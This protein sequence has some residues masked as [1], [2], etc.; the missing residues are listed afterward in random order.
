MLQLLKEEPERVQVCEKGGIWWR[1]GPDSLPHPE[2]QVTAGT[3]R[4][5]WAQLSP[6]EKTKLCDAIGYS[7]AVNIQTEK[8]KQYIGIF[9]HYFLK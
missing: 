9:L 5:I 3:G 6:S 1:K 4:G 7:E 8:P 2:L